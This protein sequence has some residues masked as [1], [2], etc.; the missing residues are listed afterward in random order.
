MLETAARRLVAWRRAV[1]STLS[2]EGDG[3]HKHVLFLLSDWCSSSAPARITITTLAIRSRGRA[4][5]HRRL[6][7]LS[8]SLTDTIRILN[9]VR[10]LKTRVIASTQLVSCESECGES[11]QPSL[12]AS[13]SPQSVTSPHQRIHHPASCCSKYF[14]PHSTQMRSKMRSGNRSQ[15][16]FFLSNLWCESFNFL[17]PS[18]LAFSKF[19]E[20]PK[21]PSIIPRAGQFPAR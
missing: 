20:D 3:E 12:K 10:V 6:C 14:A 16:L 18:F 4:H 5:Y 8:V 19:A 2:L 9:V 13:L 11:G 1:G 21:L 7:R 15:P 17:E